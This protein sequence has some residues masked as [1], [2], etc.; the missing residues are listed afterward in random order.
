MSD[1]RKNSIQGLLLFAALGAATA[2]ADVKPAALFADNMVIQ[3]QTDAA[4]WG[5]ADP[6]ETVTVSAS[7]GESATAVSDSDG[8]WFL[9]L[10][11]PEAIPGNAQ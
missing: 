4:I 1:V 6:G 8:H 5:S 7:W 10:Q 9:T 3:Q 11:T 2:S